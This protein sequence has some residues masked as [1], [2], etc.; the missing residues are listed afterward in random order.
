MEWKG[1]RERRKGTREREA[2]RGGLTP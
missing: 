1:F 2:G